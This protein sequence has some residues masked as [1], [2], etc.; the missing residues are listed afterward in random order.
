[1][2]TALQVWMQPSKSLHTLG[3]HCLPW[4]RRFQATA[5]KD[6]WRHEAFPVANIA[7]ILPVPIKFRVVAQYWWYS[8]IVPVQY[9][10]PNFW[11][12]SLLLPP[13]YCGDSGVSPV[14]RL[15]IPVPI[16]FWVV[17]QYWWYSTIVPVQYDKPNFWRNSLLSPP[18]YCGDSGVSPV[19]RLIIPV[20][21]VTS[22]AGPRLNIKTVLS[23][24]GDFHVKDKTA[25]RT[26]YL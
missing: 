10:K 14:C 5:R 15:I 1:M 9:D 26:S 21:R 4:Q 8:T 16:K 22:R 18:V 19:C 11:S 23:T 20:L 13:V 7:P 6:L 3:N 24:Y 25:V 17:A 12:N 2:C